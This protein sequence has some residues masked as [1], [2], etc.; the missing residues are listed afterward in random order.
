MDKLCV[1]ILLCVNENSGLMLDQPILNGTIR[2]EVE[3]AM[4]SKSFSL[5]GIT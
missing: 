2:S 1:P 5:S 4:L 3:G